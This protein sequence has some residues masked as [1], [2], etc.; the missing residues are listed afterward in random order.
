MISLS[1][2]EKILY[3][4]V[5][6][7]RVYQ[8]WYGRFLSFGLDYGRLRRV[9]SRVDDWFHWCGE[10]TKEGD[11]LEEKAEQAWVEGYHVQA[12]ALLQE[13]VA[14]YHIG[15]HIFFIDSRQK[16][17]TQER[18]RAC[19]VKALS[20]EGEDHEP[21]RVEIPFRHTSIPGYL[22][23][24]GLSKAPLVIFVNGM[25]NI[26]EVEGHAQGRL[27]S[28]QGLNFFTFDG[29]GQGEMWSTMKFDGREYRFAMSAIL[30]WFEERKLPGIDLEAVAFMGFS[31]GG[32]LA[33]M[34]A[35]YDPR[36]RCVVGNSGIMFIGGRKGLARLNPIWQRGV[37]YMTGCDTLDEAVG[38]FDWDIE[39]APRL[40]VPIL[41]YHSGKDE[42]MPTPSLHAE[43]L[44]R[45]AEGPK[46]LRF[47]EDAEH[48][49]QNHLDEVFPE[50]IDWLQREFRMRRPAQL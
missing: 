48:C 32:Y 41:F 20:L 45:W 46:T 34:A 39:E 17:Q 6:G 42:V 38:S 10:W 40:K 15:Q 28:R 37:T 7:D 25:D 43:K 19:Y 5:M 29:P 36:V 12:K 27:Y 18:A 16:E 49:T 30:D 33:P 2:R 26:K 8:R 11:F 22:W 44:M 31:L 4:F 13:A 14:C 24:S 21:M 35:A 47:I 3:R 23:R 1:P 9:V 50:I